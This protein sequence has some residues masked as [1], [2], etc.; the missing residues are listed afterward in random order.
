MHAPGYLVKLYRESDK[1]FL[2]PYRVVGVE[3]NEIYVDLDGRMAHFNVAQML[4]VRT[5]TGETMMQ[6]VHQSLSPFV[7]QRQVQ[8]G[9]TG[10]LS[11]QVSNVS[12]QD[13]EPD[14][15]DTNQLGSPSNATSTRILPPLASPSGN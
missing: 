5:F 12:R 14:P 4:P 6:T 7:H 2:G 3:R 1:R 15:S 13:H 11:E 8:A 10:S 9:S